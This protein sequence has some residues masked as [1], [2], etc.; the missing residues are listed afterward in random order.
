MMFLFFLFF[1]SLLMPATFLGVG[2]YFTRHTPGRNSAFGYRTPL[3]GKSDLANAFAHQYIGRLWWKIG[4][5]SLPVTVITFIILLVL[6]LDKDTTGWIGG[7]LVLLECGAMLLTILP[8]EV[9]L[10][11]NFDKDGAP[12]AGEE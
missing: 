6:Q 4:L 11:K 12:R 8:T 3:S 10:H 5:V 9:A 1:C 2:W 7:G